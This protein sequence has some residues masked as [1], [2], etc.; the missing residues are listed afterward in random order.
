MSGILDKIDSDSVTVKHLLSLLVA[1]IVVHFIFFTFFYSGFIGTYAWIY[2]HLAMHGMNFQFLQYVPY[3]SWSPFLASFLHPVF[4]LFVLLVSIP[5]IGKLGKIK[6]ETIEHYK[7]VRLLAFVAAAVL[8]WELSAYDYNY[9]LDSSQYFD[10]FLLVI[11]ALL[12]LRNPL[13]VL[14]FLIISLL[15]RSQFN[16]PIGGFALWDKR[17]LFDLLVL[18]YTYILIRVYYGNLKINLLFMMI[19]IVMSNYF[20]S[21]LAKITHSPHGYEWLAYDKIAYLF[22]NVHQ[23][24]WLQSLSPSNI[25]SV[26]NFLLRFGTIFQIIVLAIELSAIAVLWRKKVGILILIG[27]IVM[28]IGIFIF[29]SM[30]FWKWMAMDATIVFI[31]LKLKPEEKQILFNSR[32]FKISLLLVLTSAIWLKPLTVAWFDTPANQFFTYEVTDDKGNVYHLEKNSM[33]P[34][35]QFFQ[36]GDFL[37]LV[38]KNVLP[39][40]SFGYAHNFRQARMIKQSGATGIGQAE[41]EF[42]KNNFDSAK[43]EGLDNFIKTYFSNR[44][45]RNGNMMISYLAAPN[46]IYNHEDSPVYT[47]RETVKKFRVIFNQT[48]FDGEKVVAIDKHIV[49]EINIP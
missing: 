16:Y 43:A 26:K 37:Y 33:N 36:Y 1:Y 2:E 22:M 13:F 5:F 29:G 8:A 18:L 6:W 4:A 19:C 27:C 38:D 41:K 11:F 35:H 28:H 46:H 14:P 24:G 42:G 9:Y 23:S 7:W 21:G 25:D 20:A 15:Y 3:H 31:L 30:I 40:T 17:L 10:R 32:N 47:G 48:Y 34:Y 39:I 12:I 44:N 45:K 49:R